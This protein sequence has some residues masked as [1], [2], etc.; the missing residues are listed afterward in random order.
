MSEHLKHLVVLAG[1]DEPVSRVV[2]RMG[3]G[4]SK[5]FGL[6]L[7]VDSANRLLGIFNNGDLMR[8][9]ARGGDL[10]SPVSEVMISDPV[11]VE[12]GLTDASILK[13][14]RRQLKKRTGGSKELTR[15]VPV[16]D[17][18]G[19][20]L[21]VIDI[22]ELLSRS[23]RQGEKVAVYGMGF[24]G[25]TLAAALAA[26]DHTVTGIDTNTTI[27]HDLQ[28]GRPHVFEP[29]LP[30]M[31]QQGHA[32]KRLFFRTD[33]GDN[34]HQVVIIAVGT[35]VDQSGNASLNGIE[36]VCREV[37]PRVNRGDLILLRSTVPVGTTRLI[38]LPLLERLS[39][40]SVGKGF[41]VAFTP[42]RTV[43]G[44]AIKELSGLPQIV[45]GATESCTEKA[46]G[47]WSTLTTT[48]VR[49]ESLEAAELAK[50]I[51]NSYRD[52]SFAFSNGLAMLADHYNIE[53]D[54]LIASAN[55]GYPRDRIPRPSPGVGGYC[56][57]KDPFL[58]AAVA[59]GAGHGEL[60]RIGRSI[61][62][63][64][65]RYPV[66]VLDRYAARI[67]R[68]LSDMRVL[69]VGMAF[70]GIPETNDLRGS[71][72]V[73]VA[74]ELTGFGCM[75]ECYD[76]V[77]PPE[78][79]QDYGLQPTGLLS[80]ADRADAVMILNNHPYNI[81]EGLLQ[82][83]GGRA[84]LLFDGWSLLERH[85]VE[86]YPMLTYATLGYMTPENSEN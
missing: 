52:L 41:N 19:V 5:I 38:V 83:I 54:R 44:N 1:P 34:N 26:R 72:A 82:S 76:V 12:E 80:G 60:A 18:A 56:L 7:I 47:F 84:M 4:T 73:E 53:A 27:I 74:R 70:K 9:I 51:N 25:L 11:S 6:S 48:V 35:P 79:L 85:E 64:A 23:P 50:L 37:G 30:E 62:V 43:Q 57:T 14:V 17:S 20:V 55:E 46:S 66:T 78:T 40:L 31:I 13:K 8:L 71:A 22:Y 39:G 75:V 21:D 61:N 32:N 29:R 2:A 59:A 28:N 67:R 77:V 68:K 33:T 58:Y 16:L 81:P 65:G 15:Y 3:A 36:A 24:V 63:K 45:G 42:E 49:V 86:E 69:L 10:E